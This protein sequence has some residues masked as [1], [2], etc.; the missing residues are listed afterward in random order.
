MNNLTLSMAWDWLKT[1][2]YR[3]ILLL[4]VLYVIIRKFIWKR[5]GALARKPILI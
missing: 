4:L 3:A 2:P 1:N 5:K